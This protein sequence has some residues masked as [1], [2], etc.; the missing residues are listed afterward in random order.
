MPSTQTLVEIYKCATLI[1]HSSLWILSSKRWSI[2]FYQFA[3]RTF[4][5]G[6]RFELSFEYTNSLLIHVLVHLRILLQKGTLHHVLHSKLFH[7]KLQK[8]NGLSSG[9]WTCVL[10]LAKPVCYPPSGGDPTVSNDSK[11]ATMGDYVTNIGQILKNSQCLGNFFT[12]SIPL[13]YRVF[14]LGLGNPHCIVNFFH[15]FN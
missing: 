10:G 12:F 13:L 3:A 7:A 1:K 9:D 4:W 15:F 11:S 6:I 14:Y 5:H 8:E 2:I